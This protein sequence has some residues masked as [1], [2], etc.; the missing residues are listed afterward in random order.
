MLFGTVEVV[1]TDDSALNSFFDENGFQSKSL[2]K[3]IGST[4]I[5]LAIYILGFIFLAILEMFSKCTKRLDRAK[6][7]MSESLM[8]NSTLRFIL[9]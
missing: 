4:I 9:Q 6:N 3:N 5:Y 1:E 8:W 2:M 7:Y